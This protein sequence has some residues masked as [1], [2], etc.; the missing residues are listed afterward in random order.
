MED[1]IMAGISVIGTGNMGSAIAGIAAEGGAPV[2]V[3]A[4]DAVKAQ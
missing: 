4:R 2:Q 1:Q 3:V